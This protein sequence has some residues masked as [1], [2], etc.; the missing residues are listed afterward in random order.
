MSVLREEAEQHLSL[1]LAEVGALMVEILG[2]LSL[3][4]LE[5][6]FLEERYRKDQNPFLFLGLK[7]CMTTSSSSAST[8][9]RFL[10][11]VAVDLLRLRMISEEREAGSAGVEIM[12]MGIGVVVVG[13]RARTRAGGGGGCHVGSERWGR[14]GGGRSEDG[15]RE[16]RGNQLAQFLL[17]AKG[18]DPAWVASQ[19]MV[20]ALH[21]IAHVVLFASASSSASFN[22]CFHLDH[23]NPPDQRE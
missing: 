1:T 8:K 2:V 4:L 15:K 10:L 6:S 21:S 5:L 17:K 13:R 14:G 11:G 7:S 23:A 20:T 19:R 9:E 12:V 16:G 3:K 22:R 18:A